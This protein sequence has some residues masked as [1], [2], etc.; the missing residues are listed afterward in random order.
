MTDRPPYAPDIPLSVFVARTSSLSLRRSETQVPSPPPI[1]P[2]ACLRP[3]ARPA[4]QRDQ[5]DRDRR[6]HRG[7]LDSLILQLLDGSRQLGR[8]PKDAPQHADEHPGARRHR[9][10]PKAP[11][12]PARVLREREPELRA[13]L[14]QPQKRQGHKGERDPEQ[15]CVPHDAPEPGR[16]RQRHGVRTGRRRLARAGVRLLAHHRA[17]RR[18][19][20]RRRLAIG[21]TVPLRKRSQARRL[22]P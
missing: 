9:H 22:R 8:D 10:P 14:D 4:D 16:P 19:A 17:I 11:I 15:H 3:E 5:R 2:S 13:A 1:N 6:R 12:K 20:M 18:R 21:I 7:R